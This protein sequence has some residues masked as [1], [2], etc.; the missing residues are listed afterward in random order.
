MSLPLEPPV[1]LDREPAVMWG[2]TV[3]E[4]TVLLILGAVL[5]IPV[6]I[7]TGMG[8]A[9]FMGLPIAGL[10]VYLVVR[11]G[12]TRLRALKRGRP[13]YYYQHRLQRTLVRFGLKKP[14]YI[15]Y[16]GAW[17]VRRPRGLS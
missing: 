12:A 4:L 1:R 11:F 15:A 5:G 9:G 8:G 7:V 13:D 3:P 14:W 16:S 10:I 6:G 17:D 2:C